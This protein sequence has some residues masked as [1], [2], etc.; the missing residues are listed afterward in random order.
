MAKEAQ[1]RKE[2]ESGMAL[3]QAQLTFKDV[4]LDFAPEEWDCMNPAQRTLYKDV[5]VETLR[6][7]LSVDACFLVRVEQHWHLQRLFRPQPGSL[8]VC[9]TWETSLEEGEDWK[10]FD[11]I[12][13]L[14]SYTELPS[15]CLPVQSPQLFLLLLLLPHPSGVCVTG[16]WFGSSVIVTQETCKDS[17]Y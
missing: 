16:M 9:C 14:R 15:T 10:L 13:C 5:M 11:C 7:L 4:F 8:P 17:G 6:N 12:W 2:Q 1:K 3:S